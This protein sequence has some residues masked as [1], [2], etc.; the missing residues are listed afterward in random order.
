MR[1]INKFAL[2]VTLVIWH[3]LSFIKCEINVWNFLKL[4][5]INLCKEDSGIEKLQNI[6]PSTSQIT[7][8]R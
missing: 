3:K 7:K 4:S 1:D 8:K 2:F 6:P 5:G